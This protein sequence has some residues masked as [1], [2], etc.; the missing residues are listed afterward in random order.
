MFFFNFSVKKALF[1]SSSVSKSTI[2]KNI[3]SIS[4]YTDTIID[5]VDICGIK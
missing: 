5:D 3:M 1:C 4:V 2:G